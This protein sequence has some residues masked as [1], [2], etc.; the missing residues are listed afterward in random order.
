[1]LNHNILNQILKYIVFKDMFLNLLNF[2]IILYRSSYV[3]I[4]NS[5]S[6]KLV[7]RF[8]EIFS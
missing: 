7:Q 3:N 4:N 6:L 5:F 2:Y 8:F 1:M